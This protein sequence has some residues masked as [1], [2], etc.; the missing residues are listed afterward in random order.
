MPLISIQTRKHPRGW[1]VIPVSACNIWRGEFVLNTFR[2]VSLISSDTATIL[3]GFQCL[4]AFGESR[5][6]VDGLT[7]GGHPMSDLAVRISP[8]AGLVQVE[9]MLGLDFINRFR[10]IHF[11]VVDGRL[12]LELP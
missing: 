11:D 4:N 2:P 3:D 12:T 5:Y 7:I 6:L 9:G 8:A 10:S 1:I